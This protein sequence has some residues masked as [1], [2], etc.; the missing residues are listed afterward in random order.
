MN[1][2]TEQALETLVACFDEHQELDAAS[3]I[4]LWRNERDAKR[5]ANEARMR[6]MSQDSLYVVGKVEMVK[7]R[8]TNDQIVYVPRVVQRIRV[9]YGDIPAF[10]NKI[11]VAYRDLMDVLE[12]RRLEVSAQGNTW[13]TGNTAA[14]YVDRS[15]QQRERKQKLVEHK[16]EVVSQ[17]KKDEVYSVPT[18]FKEP[19]VQDWSPDVKQSV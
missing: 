13:R 7:V 14:Q 3:C 8:T 9:R 19:V 15:A 4:E 17:A 2:N 5:L 18:S 11:G 16:Q 6:A 1:T 12:L 10:A